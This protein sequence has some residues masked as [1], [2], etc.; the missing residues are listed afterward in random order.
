MANNWIRSLSFVRAKNGRVFELQKELSS[1]HSLRSCYLLTHCL[2]TDT[3]IFN[4]PLLGTSV[5]FTSRHLCETWVDE[6]DGLLLQQWE[7]RGCDS[8]VGERSLHLH[9]SAFSSRRTLGQSTWGV[10]GPANSFPLT[11]QAP[12][13]LKSVPNLK[14]KANVHLQPAVS[15]QAQGLHRSER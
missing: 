12:Y 8:K 3:N 14:T 5:A 9:V 1:S 15:V 4:W 13:S 7:K 2:S 11:I 6:R 10:E